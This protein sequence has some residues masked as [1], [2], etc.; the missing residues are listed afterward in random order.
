MTQIN[1][2]VLMSGADYFNDGFAINPYM[3]S[4]VAIDT[5]KASAEHTAIKQALE[6]SGVTVIQV[7]PP[8][9]CQDGVYTANWALCRGDTAV[10]A[11]LPNKREDETPY[12]R[13]VL[14][15]LG[16]KLIEPPDGLRF[17][18]QGDALPCGNLLF[19]GS[20]YR[21]D[22]KMHRFL[23]ETLGYSVIG[24]RTVPEYDSN[25]RPITNRIT[26]WPDSFF[27]DIDLALS[28]IRDDLIAWCPEAFT[29]AS[30]ELLHKLGGL[31]K[32]EVSLEEA[33]QGFACNLVSTGEVVVM[34]AHAPKLRAE[35]EARGLRTITPEISELAKGGGYIRCTSLTLDNK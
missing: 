1:K 20:E 33:M 3:D 6:S 8:E 28:V 7:P 22:A 10:L 34:S 2:T 24:L 14:Q 19:T 4:S 23:S 15:D 9:E 30:Q 29:P 16:K 31:E 35:I 25:Q 27:Y 26:G 13:T 18:G 17:S 12:A 11:C 5:A 32:I 21:T